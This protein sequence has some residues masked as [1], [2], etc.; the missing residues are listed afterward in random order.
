MD[1]RVESTAVL[2]ES[3]A[4]ELRLLGPF[5]LVH[6]ASGEL[7]AI[8]ATRMRAL[9]VYL[10]ATPRCTESRRTLARLLW[11]GKGDDLARQSLRQLLS[12]FRRAAD[13]NVAGLV[14]GDEAALTLDW[15]RIAIDRAALLN[16][17]ADVDIATLASVARLYRGEFAS[18]L[19]I[20]EAEFDGWLESE[21]ARCR[22]M[23]I[24]VLDRL[25]RALTDADRHE[26]ALDH[27]NRLAAIDPLREETHRLVIAA[28]AVVSGRA[29]AMSRFEH[30]R[31]LLHEELGVCPEAATLQMLETLRRQPTLSASPAESPAP[32]PDAAAPPVMS[33][34]QSVAP[35][36]VAAAAPPVGGAGPGRTTRQRWALLV[37]GLL[38]VTLGAIA[39][40][41][42]ALLSLAGLRSHPRSGANAEH[43]AV[44]IVPFGVPSGL[45][46]ARAQADVDEKAVETVFADN[47]RLSVVA[48]PATQHVDDPIGFAR[49]HRVPYVIATDLTK[50][51]DGPRADAALYD[52]ATG[53]RIFTAPT[54]LTGDA[55]RFAR[56]FY[57][58]LYP[59]VL[60]YQAHRL[61]ER[62]PYAV[63]TL[64]FQAAVERARTGSRA[65]DP[66]EIAKFEAVL[67]QDPKNLEALLGLSRSLSERAARDL[68]KGLNRL[69]DLYRASW[70]LEQAKRIAQATPQPATTMSEIAFLNGML[71]KLENKLPEAAADFRKALAY[72]PDDGIAAAE[73]AHVT[74]F[75]G[76]IQEA[77]AEMESIPNFDAGE[78]A[79]IAGETA[80]IAGHPD[81]ALVHYDKAVSVSPTVPRNYAWRSVALWRLH[82]EAEAHLSALKSQD[83]AVA[84]LPF[85]MAARAQYADKRYRDARDE[86]VKDFEKA[87]TYRTSG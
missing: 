2:P 27:A 57:E 50:T 43:A 47:P 8:S 13:P 34:A 82:R 42:E 54:M 48:W 65:V 71:D 30:F 45:H 4:L 39:V 38:V 19:E 84:Y 78:S 20:G 73:L 53:T 32:A 33:A 60:L 52:S 17:P 64:L 76:R 5:E 55:N 80:L 26:E 74:L 51:S 79:F 22:E 61:A 40:Q 59:A 35:D 29:S 3:T 81:R 72:T 12:Q 70:R 36:A 14:D 44:L 77:Y 56:S 7:I 49:A 83:M 21:R 46:D 37:A 63:S 68:S 25:V 62:D 86:C 69:D 24:R 75:M 9:I 23:A 16:V 6:R 11:A 10:A 18:G 87:L 15:A 66:P 85:W 31:V 28:E 67:A 41:N 58:A 1:T